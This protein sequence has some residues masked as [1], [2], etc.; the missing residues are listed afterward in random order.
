[1]IKIKTNSQI[2]KHDKNLNI[3]YKYKLRL[4]VYKL[5][6]EVE[7]IL[8]ISKF[9]CKS[10]MSK[11]VIIPQIVSQNL[12]HVQNLYSYGLLVTSC[13]KSSREHGLVKPLEL[14]V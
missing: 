1:M 12:K 6:N 8:Y 11:I 4:Q 9:K 14:E 3:Q 5:Q 2:L 10:I 7:H 13:S